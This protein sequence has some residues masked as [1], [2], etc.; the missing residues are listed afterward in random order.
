MTRP[1]LPSRTG[2]KPTF[3][4]VALLAVGLTTAT[5]C[6]LFLLPGKKSLSAGT[7]EPPTVSVALPMQRT[8]IEWDDYVGRF[9]ASRRVE[10]LPRVSGQIVGVH[11]KDGEI[12]QQGQLLFSIDPRPYQAAYAEAQAGLASANS[13][14]A[15]ARADLARAHRLAGDS[16]ISKSDIDQ[17]QARVRTGTANVA[18]AQAR[19]ALKSLELE[20]TQVRSPITGRVSDRR[21]DPGNLVMSGEAGS[22]TR[23]TT[24]NAL[25]P[26]YFTFDASEALYLKAMRAQE[27]S[28]AQTQVEIRLQDEPDYAWRGK[29]DFTD[30]GIDPRSGTIRMRAVIENPRLFLTPGLF[31]NMRLASGSGTPALLIPDSAVQMDQTRKTVLTV[32]AEGTVLVRA[33][34]LGPLIDGLRIVRGGLA[35]DDRVIVAGQQHAIPGA[36]VQTKPEPA[37]SQSGMGNSTPLISGSK[38]ASAS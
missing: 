36:K 38:P 27:P 33:I 11:F 6:A 8:V 32:S 13:E 14:L 31:G 25:D 22:G 7:F 28:A 1:R 16:A 3:L 2:A 12:V 17:L 35:A 4:R 37:A 10:V 29:L 19:V 21:V 30:N 5:A 20:F 34:E 15:L 18:G 23:L 9:E 26:I 24:I